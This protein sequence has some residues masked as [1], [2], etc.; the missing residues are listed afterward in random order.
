MRVLVAGGT[1]FVGSVLVPRLAEGHEVLVGTRDPSS[2]EGPGE[3]VHLDLDDPSTVGS[4]LEDVDVA[5]YLLHALHRHDFVEID[6][7]WATCFGDA[8]SKAAVGKVVYLG[9]LGK[10]GQGSEHLRSRHEVGDLLAERVPTVEVRASLVLGP[11]GASYELLRQMVGAIV[12]M[13]ISSVP[14]P[15]D[16]GTATQ[17]I[18]V[19][20][21]VTL[22]V[23]ALD[24]EPGHWDI[25]APEPLTYAELMQIEASVRG[26]ELKVM[27]V[28]PLAPRLFAPFASALSDQDLM[29]AHALFDSAGSPAIVESHALAERAG[30]RA[31][32]V[33]QA[34]ARA[35]GG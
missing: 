15:R 5:Y 6:R 8:A 1:G 32:S 35:V 3:P 34:L 28:L 26:H 14:A 22:L 16:L 25:G 13:G 10:R 4:W 12:D 21:A 30:H 19:E 29:V 20:D 23:A 33:A 27:P 24:V 31:L 17:P 9:G 2:Y 7:A 18:G 11:G